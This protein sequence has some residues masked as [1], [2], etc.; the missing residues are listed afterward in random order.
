MFFGATGR[1]RT[2]DLL[3]T[4]QLLYQLSHS[5]IYRIFTAVNAVNGIIISNFKEFAS[6]FYNNFV[7]C[8]ISYNM[9]KKRINLQLF[10]AL[11]VI[12]ITTVIIII[13]ALSCSGEKIVF[14][15][16]F[17]F[18]CYRRSDNAVS[19]GSLSD[20]ASSLG[21]A[22]YVLEYGGEYYVTLSCYYESEEAENVLA[23]LKKKELD[24]FIKKIETSSFPLYGSKKNK[25]LYEGNLNTLN[26]LSRLA[27][28]CANGLD[29]G[30]YSQSKAKGILSDIRD[31][32][33][34]LIKNNKNNGFSESLQSAADE[35][36]KF[37]GFLYAKNMRYM[38]IALA[39]RIINA[40]L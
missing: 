16:T 2:G 6:D 10:I 19:A 5:S 7:Y 3:I 36:G 20:T 37:G 9:I 23:T 4:N 29:T 22:G 12:A 40:K 30:A 11:G 27:Y 38:Q 39:D 33:N 1:I 31:A 18:V 32:L 21:G 34:G 28:D 8:E 35:C 17:Y 26:S 25:K 24:C 13:S 14:E 15:E